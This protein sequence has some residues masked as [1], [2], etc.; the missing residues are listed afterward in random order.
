MSDICKGTT[1]HKKVT[2]WDSKSSYSALDTKHA[3][4]FLHL[5]MALQF[6]DSACLF[7][8]C[9]C[10]CCLLYHHHS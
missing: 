6:L 1:P 8:L 4:S 3:K 9:Y 5:L 7:C 10:C 2:V